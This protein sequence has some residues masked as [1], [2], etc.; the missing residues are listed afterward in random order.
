VAGGPWQVSGS[1]TGPTHWQV[2][3]ASTELKL[4]VSVQRSDSPACF[5]HLEGCSRRGGGQMTGRTHAAE[6][7]VHF[8]GGVWTGV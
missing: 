4:V 2:P 6:S 8:K 3:E 1:Q 7:P 5:R